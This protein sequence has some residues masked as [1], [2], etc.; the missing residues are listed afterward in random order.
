MAGF[1][2]NHVIRGT[3]GNAWWNGRHIATLQSAELKISGDVY[4]SDLQWLFRRR[5]HDLD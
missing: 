4:L 1:N 2:V 3:G 5:H